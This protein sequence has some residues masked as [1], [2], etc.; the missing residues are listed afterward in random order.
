MDLKT[1]K[2]EIIKKVDQVND[3]SLIQAIT[4]LLDFGLSHQPL[5]DAELDASINRGLQQLEKGEGRLHEIVMAGLK[6][7][8]VRK[9]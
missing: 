4:N 6:Q 7:K 2:L 5:S 3:E 1:E 8:Y 9:S